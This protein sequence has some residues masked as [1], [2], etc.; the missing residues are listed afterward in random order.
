MSDSDMTSRNDPFPFATLWQH[1]IL[2]MLGLKSESGVSKAL[3]MT[4]VNLCKVNRTL[5]WLYRFVHFI[6]GFYM[7]TYR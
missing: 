5:S 4:E 7:S 1:I 6:R 2:S 3:N